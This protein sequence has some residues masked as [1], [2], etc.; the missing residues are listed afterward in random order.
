MR[1]ELPTGTVTFLFTDVEGSTKLLH[2]LGA[3][4]Y[5]EQLAGHRR[6][7]REACAAER[8]VEVD[9]QG[10]AFFFA[11]PSAS[12]AIAA[13]Q[14]MTDAL[15]DG[16]IHLRIGLHTGA[17]L[18]TEEGYVGDDVH[19]AARVA[20]SGHGGQVLLSEST[21]EL[22]GGLSLT[23]LGEHRLKDIAG[24]VSIYQLG[25]ERFPPLKTISN[26]NLPRP[27]SSFV[28][29]TRERE[30]L[31]ALVRN[32]SRLIT[33][34]GPGGSGKTRLAIEVASEL[35][36]AFKAGVFWIALSAIRDP[37]LVTPTVAHTLGSNDGLAAHIGERELLLLLDNFEQ[38]IEAAPELS[39]LLKGCANLR[40][41]AT[42]RELLRIDGE[43]DYPVPPL[44]EP[45]AVEL[46]CK[47]SGLDGDETIAELSRRLDE[48]PLAL[49]LAAARTRVLTPAQ[50]LNR[51]G[52]RLDLLKGGRD[53]DPRQQTLR[54]TIEWS[55]DLLT[56]NEKQ[57]F[58]RLAVFAG[59][60]TLDAAEDVCGAE[61]ELVQ[62]LVDKSL[63]RHTGER[64][65]MLETIREFARERLDEAGETHEYLDR[66]T[67]YYLDL[68][69]RSHENR[70]RDSAHER[71]SLSW[72]AREEDNVR[73]MLDHLAEAAPVEAARA[74]GLLHYYWICRGAY[75]EERGRLRALLTEPDLVNQP[76]A[77]L[78]AS[79]AEI[80]HR[81]GH[82]SAAE[83]AAREALL[84]A[85][86]G[87]EARWVA[88]SNLA[89]S[90]LGHNKLD[91]AVELGRR[92]A[93][94]AAVSPTLSET[95][96]LWALNNHGLILR[97]TGRLD[98]ARSVYQ[99]FIED[100]RKGGQLLLASIGE[101]DL[102]SVDLYD[103]NYEAAHT[104]FAS[105]RDQFLAEGNYTFNITVLRGFGLS[106]L[107]IGQLEEARNAFS[108]MLDLA[109]QASESLSFDVF[110]AASGIA[111]AAEP[112]N[113]NHATRLRGALIHLTKSTHLP[114]TDTRKLAELESLF[115]QRLYDALGKE[116][117]ERERAAGT[118]LA[119]EEAIQLALSLA[120]TTPTTY[121]K[122]GAASPQRILPG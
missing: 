36:P 42:S 84:L 61:L 65:W 98:E 78:L 19:F 63:V 114:E 48:L 66:H 108:D 91:E 120:E 100:A 121:R 95:S 16:P 33:L 75:G 51:L 11:F 115:E 104:G 26:T 87:G 82:Y 55:H 2:E 38:V 107:G 18:V 46:F 53:A 28:G 58:G 7:V 6:V 22:A 68:L 32:G 23:D 97:E 99:R 89:W 79:L 8:G 44:A 27:A 119:A 10:D 102:A 76:R 35:V 94:E 12:G 30:E 122:S 14:A 113:L 47:R 101:A 62:S 86:P 49:E 34:S 37:A 111:L 57:L 50:M 77:D 103:H 96:R 69:E 40:I 81:L 45:E 52:H 85:E 70:L 5:A 56:D 29:R 64:F 3:E 109:L 118:T 17:P 116:A 13:A 4:A 83:E 110:A 43:V 105:L 93:E 117:W 90:A 88:L 54:A 24:A 9:T 31:L 80:E 25:S 67:H 72:Y 106:A 112:A 15:A 60:C 92:C 41:L 20:A 21:S 71:E 59:G 74:A 1:L 73:A 39:H